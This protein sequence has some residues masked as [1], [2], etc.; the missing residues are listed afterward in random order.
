MAKVVGVQVPPR[1]PNEESSNRAVRAFFDSVGL[2][3]QF[4]LI[5]FGPNLAILFALFASQV[6]LPYQKIRPKHTPLSSA[7]CARNRKCQDAKATLYL[8]RRFL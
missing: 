3:T 5:L 7:G 6:L 1:A 2:F 8:V 4:G